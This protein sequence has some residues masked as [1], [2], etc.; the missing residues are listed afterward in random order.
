M[1]MW[2]AASELNFTPATLSL[3]SHLMSADMYGKSPYFA[4]AEARF[5][6]IVR[7]GRDPN[8]LTLEAQLLWD[9]RQY[10]GATK[11]FERALRLGES[12]ATGDEGFPWKPRALAGL[13][14][15]HR[16]LGNNE[17]ALECCREA[18]RLGLPDADIYIGML[19][20][21]ASES[22]QHLFWAGC[23]N[24]DHF[25]YLAQLA[26]EKSEAATDAEAKKE[27]LRWAAEW[28][29]LADKS[30]AF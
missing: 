3:I 24:K 15:A 13:G 30:V 18:S 1:A 22:Q 10:G 11:V 19:S 17:K 2:A 9:Q 28:T 5:K 4:P 27:H 6:T 8:A 7:G 25:K 16:K 12:G 23:R 26:M 14:M 21:D 20:T 29:N